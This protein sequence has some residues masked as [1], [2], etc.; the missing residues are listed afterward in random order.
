MVWVLVHNHGLH[1]D[2]LG[3]GQAPPGQAT[4]GAKFIIRPTSTSFGKRP[5]AER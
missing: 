5:H 2:K 1:R 3:G 4:V